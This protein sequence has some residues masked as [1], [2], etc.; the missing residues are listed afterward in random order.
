[1][2]GM[3]GRHVAERE[4]RL[5]A[6]A[7]RDSIQSAFPP[8]D[9]PVRMSA[10]PPGF[11]SRLTR[12]LAEY[13][14][15]PEAVLEEAHPDWRR[16]PCDETFSEC[17]ARLMEASGLGVHQ[18]SRR[19]WLD[20]GYV[21]RLVNLRVDPLNPRVGERPR[22]RQPSRDAILRLGLA[23]QLPIEEMDA[24]LLAAGFAP[25]LR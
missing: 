10:R 19:S 22:Y 7:H 13:V 11:A 17:L 25:L 4:V 9:V 23:M 5:Q 2:N 18:L 12:E 3:P 6:R 14:Q 16:L 20:I 24:L 21:S 1:M 15:E 8:E